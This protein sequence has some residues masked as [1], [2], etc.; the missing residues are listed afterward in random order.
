MVQSVIDWGPM[1]THCGYL[2]ESGNGKILKMVHAAKGVL[3]QICRNLSR[4]QSVTILEKHISLRKESPVIDFCYPL[5]NNRR[6]KKTEAIERNRY[7]GRQLRCKTRILEERNL[8]TNNLRAYGKL[9]RNKCVFKSCK[10]INYRSDNSF[11]QTIHGNYIQIVQFIIDKNDNKEYTVCRRVIV[12]EFSDECSSLKIVQ[13]ITDNEDVV[14]TNDID[15]ACVLMKI[16]NTQY[17]STLPN[18][19]N[20]HKSTYF[21]Y[22]KLTSFRG[23]ST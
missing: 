21:A 10:K 8:G 16:N 20:L 11:A 12:Q 7:F 9:V 22:I 15:K 6:T 2:F 5:D 18:F 23:R 14:E 13:R 1:W 19:Q 17:I 3:N 4:N